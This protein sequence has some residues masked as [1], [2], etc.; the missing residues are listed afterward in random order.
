MIMT[1]QRYG[2]TPNCSIIFPLW[3]GISD[4][5]NTV[6]QTTTVIGRP[7]GSN[8]PMGA[9]VWSVHRMTTM[10][11]E[12]LTSVTELV[13]IEAPSATVTETLKPE[14][15]DPKHDGRKNA[16]EAVLS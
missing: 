16:V 12:V 10:L 4:G 6:D 5:R 7:T 2:R 3:S 11:V 14:F 13:R 15:Y 8:M 1:S 9:I